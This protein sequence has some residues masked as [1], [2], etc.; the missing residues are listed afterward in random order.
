MMVY[1]LL[2][3]PDGHPV[4]AFGDRLA[5]RYAI[6]DAREAEAAPERLASILRMLSEQLARQRAAGSDYLVGR[7]VSAADIYWAATCA[8]VRPLPAEACPMNEGMR[9]S[10]GAPH[11]VI[12]AAIDPALLAH[13]DRI[14]EQYM[15]YP[16]VLD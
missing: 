5:A 14:Y 1:P 6:G 10:Y 8:L 3:L 16:V 11:P 9:A 4:R 15:E 2:Q 13:R 12:D 7:A